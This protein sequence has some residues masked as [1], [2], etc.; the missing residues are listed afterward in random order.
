MQKFTLI[1]GASGGIGR[2]MAFICA[3]KSFNLLLVALA[4]SNLA[5]LSEEL[6]SKYAV[7]VNFLELDFSRIDAATDLYEWC[8]QNNYE[9]DMLINNLG[10]GGKE[11]FKDIRLDEIR[12]MIQ[13]NA[14]VMS[15]IT[16]LFLPM[17]NRQ[18]RA[19]I[20]NV[21]STASY[22]NI[23]NKIVYSAT[24]AYVNTF[25]TSLRNELKNSHV[26]VSLLCHGGSTHRVDPEV[27]KKLNNYFTTLVHETPHAIA[28]AGIEGM[29]KNKKIILPGFPSKFYMVISRIIPGFLAD[30][31]VRK[32]FV[33]SS[34]KKNYPKPIQEMTS[35]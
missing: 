17:L 8:V 21:S 9:V 5:E 10:I 23:P 22:F 6:R 35:H 25:T 3:E 11:K 26:S 20:L 33:P 34:P 15:A 18:P 2:E 30:K 16:N 4:N 13:L 29:L 14:Y 19:Y 12:Q 28:K 31:L 27:E 1:T 24:K 7:E 32:L